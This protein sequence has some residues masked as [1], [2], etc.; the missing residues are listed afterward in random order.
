MSPND[1]MVGC[2][3]RKNDVGASS[4][5]QKRKRNMQQLESYDL[6]RDCMDVVTDQLKTIAKWSD[7]SINQEDAMV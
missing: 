1:M 4:S 2:S 5:G 3:S 7:K 6:V